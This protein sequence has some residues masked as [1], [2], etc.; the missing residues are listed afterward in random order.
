MGEAFFAVVSVGLAL[1][2]SFGLLFYRGYAISPVGVVTPF[3]VLSIGRFHWKILN[4]YI[5][6]VSFCHVLDKDTVIL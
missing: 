6:T 4:N 2:T 1:A 3:L 5:R